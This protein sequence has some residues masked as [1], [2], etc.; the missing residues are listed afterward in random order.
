MT[1]HSRTVLALPL[2]TWTLLGGGAPP[3][4]AQRPLNLDFERSS[5]SY[6]DRPWGWTF[7]WSAFAGGSAASFTL[8]STVH[9]NGRRSLHIELPDSVASVSPQG[10]MLQLPAD[11]FR[12]R[13]VRLAVWATMERLQGRAMFTL[14]AWKDREFSAADTA[15]LSP[16]AGSR[17]WAKREVR[18]RV[19]DDSAV[20]SVVITLAVVGH[21][22]V[23]FDDLTLAVNGVPL[24]TLPNAADP[25]GDAE[26]AWLVRH[27]FP[28][29]EV[30]APASGTPDDTDL[31]IVADIVSAARVVGLGESTHGTREFF[32]VKHRLLEYLVRA[33]GFSVFAIEANQLAVERLNAYVQGGSG[34]ARDAMRVMFQVWN[35]EEMLALVQWMRDYN[36]THRNQRIRF[37]GY[38]MQDHRTPSDTLRAF[39]ARTERGLLD[40]FDELAGE[41]RTQPTSITPQIADTVRARW[42]GQAEMLWAVVDGRRSSWLM[43]ASDRADT[44]AVEWAVQAANLLRQAA[45][46]NVALS[47]PERDSLM[48]ANLDWVLRTLTP[49]ARAVVWAHDVHVSHGGDPRLSFNGGAQMGTYIRR[50]G[51]DYRAVT[52]L[53]YDGA[54]SAT[55]SFSD[56]RIIEAE[57]FPAPPSSIEEALHRLERPGPNVGWIVDLRPA[58]TDEGSQ[59]LRRP[60]PIRHIGYAA[61]DY[62]FEF[63]AVLPLE[64][65]GVVFI[66]RT[67]ASRLLR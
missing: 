58:R 20:H 63:T 66:D 45:R 24:T 14:E 49:D 48:A 7:G 35:T 12:G 34:T 32:Q 28:L 67:T 57:A 29:R 3:A 5:V 17:D 15:W 26:L 46:F 36:A 33:L 50:Y 59:W 52:L 53:T 13:E 22:T 61:Y 43:R 19:P 40:R 42:A 23:W 2:L 4:M 44:M 62:G 18:I 11:S 30:R 9:R 31:W 1:Y 16:D 65:D 21:G 51:Y 38:D 25:P 55:R 60:R 6:A 41:Y 56:H 47:S 64:F 39:L 37:V 54:Y 27:A 8:D 10:I